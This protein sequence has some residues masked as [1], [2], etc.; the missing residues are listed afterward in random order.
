MIDLERTKFRAKDVETGEWV[1]GQLVAPI[2][3]Y[4]IVN[5]D[6][7][8]EIDPETLGQCT[9]V[10]D[11]K[12]NDIYEGDIVECVSWNEYFSITKDGKTIENPFRRIMSVIWKDGAFRLLEKFD[13]VMKPSVWDMIVNFDLSVI[14]NIYDNPGL[15]SNKSFLNRIIEGHA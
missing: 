10:K 11:C 2:D 12:K 14:G 9:T 7:E 13:G 5:E 6:D 3:G 4:Y 8:Y 1:Y 15:D